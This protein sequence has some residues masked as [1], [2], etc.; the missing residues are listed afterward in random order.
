MQKS[1]YANIPA[2][3][4]YDERLPAN[5]KLLYGEITALCNEKGYCWATNDYFA[6]LYK[7]KKE[8]VSRWISS[9]ESYGYIKTI[10]IY[11]QG[12]KQVHQR[13]IILQNQYPIEEKINTPIDKKVKENITVINTTSNNTLEKEYIP[14]EEIIDHLNNVAGTSYRTSTKKTKQF[15]KAR[16]KEGFQLT[17][18]K[19]VIEKKVA[20]WKGTDMAKYIRPETLFGTKFEGYLNEKVITAN[21]KPKNFTHEH[22]KDELE[23]AIKRKTMASYGMATGGGS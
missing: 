5:A 2:N 4:R 12:S 13:K 14:F 22:S 1:Y 6:K 11:K 23:E 19:V 10:L 9:L 17:D 8:T 15:I 18:F 21:K 7:V 20:E 16:F 3:V